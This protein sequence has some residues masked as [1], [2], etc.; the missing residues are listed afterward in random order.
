MNV[1]LIDTHCHTNFQAFQEDWEEAMDRALE[2]GVSHIVVGTQQ[3]TS[4]RA[5]EVARMR[6][7][8]YAAVGLHPIHLSSKEVDEEESSFMSREESFD[9]DAYR[10]LASDENVVAIGEMGLDY[11][12]LPDDQEEAERE[13]EKQHR[14][15][16][17]AIQL[18]AELEKPLIIHTRPRAGTMDAYDDLLRVAEEEHIPRGVVHCFGGTIHHAHAFVE[19]GLFI[20]CTGIVTFRNAR[21][22][23][24][25]VAEVPLERILIETDAPYLAPEPHRG[26]RNEPAFVA[27]VA[28]KIADIKGV[29]VEE[30][31]RQT[32]ENARRLFGIA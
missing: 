3:D 17:Q 28:E 25:V 24:E 12:R 2:S 29:S 4:R 18:S 15:F 1:P 30:V 20:G 32:T 10:L 16:R 9:A 7:G 19:M 23:Q 27:F 21:E 8:V 6:E 22:L 14:V 13:K 31:A 26:M 11:F 5:V